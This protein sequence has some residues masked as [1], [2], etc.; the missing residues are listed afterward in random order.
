MQS[1]FPVSMYINESI[2]YIEIIIIL[3][4]IVTL[5]SILFKIVSRYSENIQKVKNEVH[6]IQVQIKL[7]SDIKLSK[8]TNDTKDT[9]NLNQKLDSVNDK[10]KQNLDSINNRVNNI[11]QIISLIRDDLTRISEENVL[12]IQ[13][14]NIQNV[15]TVSLLSDEEV[16]SEEE[17]EDLEEVQDISN[18]ITFIKVP[19]IDKND[20]KCMGARWS[21]KYKKWYI[22][23]NTNRTPFLKKWKIL[24]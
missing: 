16:L 15:T 5:L 14:S 9:I 23:R 24:I 7:I 2:N 18:T 11:E 8:N 10:L 1:N 22:P 3:T 20:A 13:K 17:E 12:G 19:Y 4:F 21:P 6:K